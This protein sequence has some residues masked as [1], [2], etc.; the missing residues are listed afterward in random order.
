AKANLDLSK[1]ELANAQQNLIERQADQ[2]Q[3]VQ[4]VAD[5]EQNLAQAEAELET[6][7]QI[8]V[9]KQTALTEA[10]DNLAQAE[11]ELETL[12]QADPQDA[13][14]IA[15]QELVVSEA[16]AAASQA[17]S[18]AE[19]AEDDVTAA[20]TEVLN[21]GTALETEK[22]DL[23][24]AKTAT[25]NAQTLVKEKQAAVATREAE[26]TAAITKADT[27]TFG[28]VSG[29][30]DAQSIENAIAAVSG[31]LGTKQTELGSKQIELNGAQ[32]QAQS[33]SDQADV[34]AGAAV[35]SGITTGGDL[36]LELALAGGGMTSIG[37][38]DNALGMTVGGTLNVSTG[39]NTNL[40]NVYLESGRDLELNPISAL[41]KVR[42][43]S[44]GS[45]TGAGTDN[46]ITA[47]ETI[48]N[49]V[50]GTVGT[51]A[52]SPLC[53]SV[54]Q[55]TA[56]GEH[57]W[58]RNDKSLT[59]GTIV[60][61]N[62]G[63]T[64]SGDVT[65]GTP[66]GG[67]SNI[68]ADDLN[69][70]AT[71]SIGTLSDRL[72][73]EAGEISTDS[74]H[75][76]I[77]SEGD[78]V[79]DRMTASGAVDLSS[80]GIV[81]DKGTGTAIGANQLTIDAGGGIGTADQ[82]LNVNVSGEVTTE[83][84]YGTANIKNS[85]TSGG[86]GNG[87]GG[88]GAIP[89]ATTLIHEPTGV[90]VSG[91][92]GEDAVLKVTDPVANAE[93]AA[94]HYLN[95]IRADK[96][97]AYHQI[98]LE[99]TFSG[100]LTV[101]IPVDAKYEGK[102]LTVITY[103]NGTLKTMDLTVKGGYVTFTTETL[104]SYM[105]LDGKYTVATYGKG[106]YET[107]NGVEYPL[108]TKRFVDVAMTDWFY[109]YVA[110]VSF[111]GMMT[112]VSNTEFAP[113]DTATRGMMVTILYRLIGASDPVGDTSFQDVEPDSW[114]AKAAAWAEKQGVTAGFEDGTF[115]PNASITREQF[116]TMLYSYAK[117]QGYDISAR[118]D[119]SAF[120]D[121]GEISGF[122]QEAMS[123]AVAVGLV[124]GRSGTVIAAQDTATRGELA[125]IIQHF[126]ECYGPKNLIINEDL[127]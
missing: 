47:A 113:N 127:V 24:T 94:Y 6:A 16:Q 18:E 98:K 44:L 31:E 69:I 10:N 14:A 13:E 73:I 21:H 72:M 35:P 123:W 77:G 108:G 1:A 78:L 106:Q 15:A 58:I 50:H 9:E 37:E 70:K 112:G 89:G 41:G 100:K 2:T 7:E 111:L 30:K 36:N 64:V 34:L 51:S 119:L 99:G 90:R 102:E 59:V 46:T 80:G 115:R 26:A 22:S 118:A 4:N 42:I 39:K 17:Q 107:S 103:L 75:A 43:D 110:Y 62:V 96:A 60:G 117:N 38:A 20:Q 57:V 124:S 11:T 48:L 40:A 27:D 3:A 55:V 114:Y 23:E 19:Q 32:V 83:A 125:V 5:A 29:L 54:D 68:V 104:S 87:G 79:V 109:P 105:V 91:T 97:L 81:S 121:S 101:Q 95:Q 63:L 25:A 45:I 82:P 120:R 126:T 53:T 65:S 116:V 52:G 49:S 85:Y 122:A 88:G 92:I 93:D 84:G 12:K 86:G 8:K 61:G 76:F 28:K 71:G 56:S 33:L 74:N 67:D 66:T